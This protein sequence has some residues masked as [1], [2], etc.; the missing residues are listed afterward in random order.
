MRHAY[1]EGFH[2]VSGRLSPEQQ[3][4]A[5]ER[6]RC[7]VYEH[8]AYGPRARARDYTGPDQAMRRG[9]RQFGVAYAH[10]G[11]RRDQAPPI[12]PE[13]DALVAG[14]H[15][16][17]PAGWDY[18][19]CVAMHYP[20]GTDL[21]WHVDG[22]RFGASICG[23]SFG[24]PAVMQFRRTGQDAVAY[25]IQLEPGSVYILS[26][27]A[28]WDHEHRVLPLEGER[29]NLT[30]RCNRGE[31]ADVSVAAETP[32]RLRA[33]KIAGTP[34]EDVLGAARG[35]RGSYEASLYRRFAGT[36]PTPEQTGQLIA[37]LKAEALPP[38]AHARLMRLG[39]S[40]DVPFE[41]A[42]G[43][44]AAATAMPDDEALRRANERLPGLTLTK[45]M[46]W[47]LLLIARLPVLARIYKDETERTPNRFVSLFSAGSAESDSGIGEI[48]TAVNAAP[49]YIDMI[50]LL[51]TGHVLTPA[52]R[53]VI[54]GAI[55]VG[56]EPG[57][58]AASTLAMR[59]MAEC[60]DGSVQHVYQAF[61]ASFG[62]FHLGAITGAALFLEQAAKANDMHA[63]L[64]A[65]LGRARGWAGRRTGR[66]AGFGHSSYRRD[67]RAALLLAWCRD[68]MPGAH[69]ARAERLSEILLERRVGAINMDG[70]S[71]AMILQM[72]VPPYLAAMFTLIARTPAIVARCS[73]QVAGRP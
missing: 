30:Y 63:F 19:Q 49:T 13:F 24:A 73:G 51:L 12:P 4:T 14:Q 42:F 8:K 5:I 21:G 40:T 64:D 52:E 56:A 6:L 1:W 3:H 36:P 68:A 72:G 67:P 17:L 55:V 53:R 46:L 11:G 48:E 10:H 43:C 23:I 22:H 69:I 54:N 34:V 27:P 41:T 20:P 18:D 15:A 58:A 35:G 60:C 47:G 50:F 65:Y 70:A 7:I 26:G 33:M 45:E 66:I 57:T 38:P 62:F 29:F 32:H 25:E 59:T 37:L 31:F 9:Y 16:L 28:R 61:L 39:A 44:V 71:A 2:Y